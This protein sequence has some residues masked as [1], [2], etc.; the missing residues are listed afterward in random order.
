MHVYH[1]APY[2]PAALKR[3]MGRHATCE[4]DIDRMLR[5][6]LFVD[7][8]AIV[9]Q[10]IRAS[11]ESYTIKNLEAFYDYRRPVALPDARRALAA[12]QG[13][14]ELDDLAAIKIGRASCRERV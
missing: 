4:E 14:L 5:G 7:L 1:Y 13:C 6:Q 8:F 9:K 10:G 3:L 11:V 12:I 2:E